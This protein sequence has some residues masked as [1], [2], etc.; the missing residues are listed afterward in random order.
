VIPVKTKEVPPHPLHRRGFTLTELAI[1]LGI[2]G[3]I[4]GAIWVAASRVYN[5]QKTDTA[6]TEILAIANGV[7]AMYP[8]GVIS[9]GG[10]LTALLMNNGIISADMFGSC[11]TAP[12]ST[13]SVGNG[14]PT[15]GCAFSPWNQQ[16]EVLSQTG[17]LFTDAVNDFD[18]V[19]FDGPA[20]MTNAQ[21]ASFLTKLVSSAA[22]PSAGAS[23]LIN[24]SA[25]GI[26]SPMS[27]T[28]ATSP[29]VF[30]SCSD[31][32]YLQFQL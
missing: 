16:I 6:V 30:A 18:I 25:G 26:T 23:G 27:V 15:N 24:V 8:G 4:L 32:V 1:V 29:T 2:I 14:G 11:A 28:T 9:T 7:R 21:C 19:L 5:N 20:V 17:G 12:W 22:A 10:I 3:T 13:Q 31:H